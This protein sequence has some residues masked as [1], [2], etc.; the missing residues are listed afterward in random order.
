MT[1]LMFLL[2]IVA[3]AATMILLRLLLPLLSTWNVSFLTVIYFC[4]FSITF[5]LIPWR[6]WSIFYSLL[7]VPRS[8]LQLGHVCTTSLHPSM[9]NGIRQHPRKNPK[10]HIP[11]ASRMVRLPDT[12]CN[13]DVT[14]WPQCMQFILTGC[15]RKIGVDT[16]MTVDWSV[17]Y[18]VPIGPGPGIGAGP[19][20]WTEPGVG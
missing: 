1:G 20:A 13:R 16:A 15:S 12:C 10:K 17:W 5:S 18:G 3:A 11:T 4:T 7:N 9:Q 19:D 6:L 8:L 2:V 14:F